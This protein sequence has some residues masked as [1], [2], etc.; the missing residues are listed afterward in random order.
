[1]AGDYEDIALLRRG[2]LERLFPGAEVLAERFG[3]F[4][5]SWIAIGS[6]P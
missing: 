1:M 6:R 5:K 4:A 3:P 2:E